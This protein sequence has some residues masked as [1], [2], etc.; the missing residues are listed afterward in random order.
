MEN[1]IISKRTSLLFDTLVL[2]ERLYEKAH[3]AVIAYFGEDNPEAERRF[4]ECFLPLADYIDKLMLS[5]IS[6][7]LFEGKREI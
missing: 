1:Y 5:S 3:E 6:E 7:N 4:D 2:S